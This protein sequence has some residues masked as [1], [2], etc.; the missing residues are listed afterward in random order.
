MGRGLLLALALAASTAVLSAIVPGAFA[1]TDVPDAPTAVAVRWHDSLI[2]SA[3][4]ATVSALSSI[5]RRSAN[6]VGRSTLPG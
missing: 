4:A 3:K 6:T 5:T 2:A 1:Q